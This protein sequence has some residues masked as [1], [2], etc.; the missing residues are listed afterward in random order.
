MLFRSFFRTLSSDEVAGAICKHAISCLRA[1]HVSPQR[2]GAVR[3]QHSTC[4]LRHSG[5]LSNCFH[6]SRGE[7]GKGTSWRA[8]R[9]L[10]GPWVRARRKCPAN[11]HA[12]A[13]SPLLPYH[14]PPRRA[15][16][17]SA[18]GIASWSLWRYAKEVVETRSFIFREGA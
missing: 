2:D 1:S 3:L 14:R 10:P 13:H 15:S 9:N 4:N 17:S 16:F 7:R 8:R 6:G 12:V 11:S 5:H 18:V